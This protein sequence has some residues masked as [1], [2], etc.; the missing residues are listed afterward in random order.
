MI[1]KRLWKRTDPRLVFLTFSIHCN[2]HFCMLYY[3]HVLLLALIRSYSSILHLDHRVWGFDVGQ[4]PH[5]GG[6]LWLR[7]APLQYLFLGFLRY[8]PGFYLSILVLGLKKDSVAS[9]VTFFFTLED[10]TNSAT[11]DY[12]SVYA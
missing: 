12:R 5:L 1:K 3:Y 10:T 8:L 9:V 6:E 7:L 2:Y 11:S 4:L